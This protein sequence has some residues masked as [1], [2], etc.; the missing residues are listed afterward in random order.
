MISHSCLCFF[1]NLSAS[2]SLRLVF[3]RNFLF[4]R[5]PFFL[6]FSNSL[7]IPALAVNFPQSNLDLLTELTFLA[8]LSRCLNTD[9]RYSHYPI[10]FLLECVNAVLLL[11]L[12]LIPSDLTISI[13]VVFS[14][15]SVSEVTT[16]YYYPANFTIFSYFLS[17]S[18]NFLTILIA[19]SARLSK[20]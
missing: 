4:S 17:L 2:I 14:Y 9:L 3:L 10:F 19:S 1:D 6:F 18:F 20:L 15:P 11:V 16:L 5:N 12:V 8:L 7:S 13:S